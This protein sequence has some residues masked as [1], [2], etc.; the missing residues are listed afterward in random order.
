MDRVVAVFGKNIA[1]ENTGGLEKLLGI[2]SARGWRIVCETR[3]AEHLA[4]LGV[5]GHITGTPVDK[6][7]LSDSGA[8]IL[9]SVGGDGTFLGAADF[10]GSS[11]IP[12][13]GL[14]CGRLGFL[15][16][17]SSD[18]IDAAADS[19]VSGTYGI[20]ERDVLCLKTDGFSDIFALNE[21]SVLR[22][23]VASLLNMEVRINGQ[24]FTSYWAD[25]LVVSTPTGS[26]AYSMSAGGP[27]I[28]PECRLTVLTPVCPH[29]LTLRP[30][31]IPA[32]SEI[33]IEVGSRSGHFILSADSRT[34]KCSDA[35]KVRI[36]PGDFKIRVVQLPGMN[37][38]DTLR[39]KLHWGE[40][41][42]NTKL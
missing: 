21:V 40:D 30:V 35:S 23:D 31:A 4:G 42:R 33:D 39:K 37:F 14:N 7:S 15:A 27:I 34:M 26:T 10:A 11:G 19:I 6:H 2:L 24:R 36:V 8:E 38:Y 41:L 22:S 16:T 28:C 18:N 20:S 25:G 32:D 5:H 12:I 17:V 3:F 29:N 9:L 1:Q 13:L